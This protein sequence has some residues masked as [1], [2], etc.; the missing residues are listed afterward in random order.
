MMLPQKVGVWSDINVE[1]KTCLASHRQS[2]CATGEGTGQSAPTPMDE[3]QAEWSGDGGGGGH[4]CRPTR[5]RR[6]WYVICITLFEMSVNQMYS[7]CVHI[8]IYRNNWDYI[9]KTS[10]FIQKISCSCCRSKWGQWCCSWAMSAQR[11]HCTLCKPSP[12]A[13]VSS[14]MQSCRCRVTPS[15]Q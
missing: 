13:A 12:P 14:Q 3:K 10:N 6:P 8:F 7:S 4:R 2:V 5:S 15:M 11:L 9:H 1:G